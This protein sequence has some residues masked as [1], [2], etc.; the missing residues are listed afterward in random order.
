MERDEHDERVRMMGLMLV[1]AL[2]LGACREG[3]DDAET[4]AA[5][6]QHWRPRR[7]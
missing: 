4:G 7:C 2:L 3:G 6:A 1:P 5:T